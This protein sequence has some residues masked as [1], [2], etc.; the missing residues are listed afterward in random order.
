ME[1]M[2]MKILSVEKTK[3]GYFGYAEDN[4]KFINFTIYDDK[5]VGIHEHSNINDYEHFRNVIWKFNSFVWF[6]KKPVTVNK[7]TKQTVEK[8]YEIFKKRDWNGKDS[9]W[10]DE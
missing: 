9:P 2:E 10:E 3:N 8:A 5:N 1:K 4:S 6:A 7:L